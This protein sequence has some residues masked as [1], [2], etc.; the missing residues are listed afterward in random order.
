M[1]G[2]YF[3][4]HTQV[5]ITVENHKQDNNQYYKRYK[6][7]LDIALLKS[8]LG[9]VLSLIARAYDKKSATDVLKGLGSLSC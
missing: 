5:C 8:D 6:T 3:A 7:S 2:M 9:Y 4:Y 1:P